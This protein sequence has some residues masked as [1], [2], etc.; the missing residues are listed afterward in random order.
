MIHQLWE[1]F[2]LFL[3][4]WS[5][6]CGNP[7]SCFSNYDPPT[8]RD[9][10]SCFS[11]YDPPTARDSF[12]YSSKFFIYL[13][14]YLCQRS[15]MNYQLWETFFLFLK[16]WYPPIAWDSFFSSFSCSS[17]CDRFIIFFFHQDLM[18]VLQEIFFSFPQTNYV[19]STAG[20]SFFRPS[21]YNRP[22]NLPLTFHF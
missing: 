19:P 3:K 21:Y 6:N 17:N 1:S 22:I 11:N 10:F 8:A 12:F 14:I 5:T 4:L 15:K 16:L 18:D 2:F 9:S 20:D 7:F 13:F